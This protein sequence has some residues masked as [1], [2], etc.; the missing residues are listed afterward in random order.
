MTEF[1]EDELERF[2]FHEIDPVEEADLFNRM[3]D[4]LLQNPTGQVMEY[5]RE[6]QRGA[7]E[8]LDVNWGKLL[9]RYAERQTTSPSVSDL[10]ATDKAMDEASLHRTDHGVSTRNGNDQLTPKMPKQNHWRMFAGVSMTVAAV[11]LIFTS[12]TY[13]DIRKQNDAMTRAG[14]LLAEVDSNLPMDPLA[15]ARLAEKQEAQCRE[16]MRLLSEVNGTTT[17]MYREALAQLVRL[18]DIY[19]Q[20]GEPQ[21]KAIRQLRDLDRRLYGEDDPRYLRTLQIFASFEQRNGDDEAALSLNREIA[22][23]TEGDDHLRHFYTTALENI[24][25]LAYERQQYAQARDAWQALVD[26][27]QHDFEETRWLGM[28]SDAFKGLGDERK[29]LQTLEAKITL[30]RSLDMHPSA[31]TLMLVASLHSIAGDYPKAEEALQEARKQFWN[32]PTVDP[33]YPDILVML[34]ETEQRLGKYEEQKALALDALEMLDVAD[35]RPSVTYVQALR[36][37]SNASESLGEYDD[38][39]AFNTRALDAYKRGPLNVPALLVPLYM[40]KS[41]IEIARGNPDAGLEAAREAVRLARTEISGNAKVNGLSHDTLANAYIELEKYDDAERELEFAQKNYATLPNDDYRL[42]CNALATQAILETLRG[43]YA[44]AE[45]H[46][47]TALGKMPETDP[48]RAI[49]QNS[50]VHIYTLMD[51][52]D[53][54]R[55]LAMSIAPTLN[56]LVPENVRKEHRGRTIRVN[57]YTTWLQSL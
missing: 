30:L 1:T 41:D 49:L 28:L 39:I 36:Q 50:L 8:S 34:A 31:N 22:N 9:S 13:T 6:I 17:P 46:L 2:A 26:L 25:T 42:D 19:Q 7:E 44:V 37:A 43:E 24:G 47:K 51:R 20:S 55:R 21:R 57:G 3:R 33:S 23:L 54:A 10:Y 27:E 48:S 35:N 14:E 53:D 29:R 12:W 4:D 38:A 11:V 32:A 45:E 5:M 40:A 16:A 15:D 18:F 56:Q 52:K